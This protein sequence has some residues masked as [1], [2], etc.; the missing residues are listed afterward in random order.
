MSFIQQIC[1]I[2]NPRD[3]SEQKPLS[4][5]KHIFLVH[6]KWN[7]EIVYLNNTI[8]AYNRKR[9][10]EQK[11]PFTVPDNKMYLPFLGMDLRDHF[12]KLHSAR[13]KFSPSTQE[14]KIRS[15][16]LYSYYTKITLIVICND[17]NEAD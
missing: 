12:R 15:I 2:M 11:V 9:L 6:E 4:A 3:G 17:Q 5:K 16:S 1:L 7:G 14:D 8:T 13:V 10:I